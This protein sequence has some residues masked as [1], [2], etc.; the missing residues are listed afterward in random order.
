[1][2]SGSS[3][4]QGGVLGPQAPRP[5]VWLG[6][7]CRDTGSFGSSVNLRDTSTYWNAIAPAV[8]VFTG[9]TLRLSCHSHYFQAFSSIG[10]TVPGESDFNTAP[11]ASPFMREYQD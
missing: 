3:L 5:P 7:K 1:M 6:T 10:E 11:K 9:F 8:P 4:Q 2:L